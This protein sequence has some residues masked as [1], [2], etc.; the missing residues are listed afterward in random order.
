MEP[1]FID[2]NENPNPTGEQ[3]RHSKGF[4]QHFTVPVAKLKQF[5]E[6]RWGPSHVTD[7]AYLAEQE[8]MNRAKHLVV[9]E[10]P[11][12]FELGY[13]APIVNG[14]M[15]TALEKLDTLIANVEGRKR[16]MEL[17]Y[18]SGAVQKRRRE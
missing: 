14:D 16:L 15:T 7:P 6:G 11:E 3:I 4:V 12:G 18:R 8:R 9:E 10:L 2:L 17:L 1:G 13:D 5:L